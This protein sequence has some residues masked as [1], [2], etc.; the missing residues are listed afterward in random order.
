MIIVSYSANQN[1]PRV[2]CDVLLLIRRDKTE[3]L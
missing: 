1:H 2:R 3:K